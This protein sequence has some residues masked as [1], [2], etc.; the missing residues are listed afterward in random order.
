[1]NNFLRACLFLFLALPF[2][3][4]AADPAK[5]QVVFQNT[6][7]RCHAAG[8]TSLQTPSEQ[9]RALLKSGRIKPHRFQLDE[10]DLEDL[11]AYLDE[12]RPGQ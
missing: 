12:S 3:A 9:V 8:P 2:A 10:T 7:V 6:C 1:M 5:G 11:V 4:F